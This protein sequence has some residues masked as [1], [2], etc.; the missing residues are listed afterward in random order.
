MAAGWLNEPGIGWAERARRGLWE[1]A[2]NAWEQ[3][4]AAQVPSEHDDRET[5]SESRPSLTRPT[6]AWTAGARLRGLSAGRSWAEAA[7]S[8]AWY[9]RSATP[10]MILPSALAGP[11]QARAGRSVG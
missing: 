4:E 7:A 11:G 9:R 2:K 8:S 10:R 6:S 3:R 5:P 1:Q